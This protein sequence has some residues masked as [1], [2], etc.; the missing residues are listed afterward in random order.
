MNKLIETIDTLKENVSGG[1]QSTILGA[2]SMAAGGYMLYTGDQL[3]WG[4]LGGGLALVVTR[5]KPEEKE[6]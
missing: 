2:V 3:G 1:W 5:T 6:A 4:L